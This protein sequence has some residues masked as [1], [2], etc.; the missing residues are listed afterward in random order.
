MQ[1]ISL[2]ATADSVAEVGRRVVEL[3]EATGLPGPR[4]YGL[5]L[6]A[7]EIVTNI[8]THG[9]DEAEIRPPDPT[10]DLEWGCEP[11]RVWVRLVDSARAFDPTRVPEPDDLNAPLDRREPGGL[12]IH[13]ART[14]L[15][16]FTYRRDRGRNHVTLAVDRRPSTENGEND[17]ADDPHRR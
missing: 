7:E 16:E 6:A 2:P 3:G 15:D 10:F 5:R 13:L 14:S 11:G 4:R 8:V 1:R 17:G 12:G 9:Y